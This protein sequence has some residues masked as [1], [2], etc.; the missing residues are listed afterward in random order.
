[1][2]ECFIFI[3]WY[4][5]SEHYIQYCPNSWISLYFL[6]VCVLSVSTVRGCMNCF[7]CVTVIVCVK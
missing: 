5:S 7:F 1:M 2:K 4:L 3:V 6:C